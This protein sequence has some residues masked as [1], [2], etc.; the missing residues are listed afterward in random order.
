[1]SCVGLLRAELD[2]RAKKEYV[3]PLLFAM[4]HSGAG[5]KDKAFEYLEQARL[6]RQSFLT[7]LKVEPLFDDIRSDPRFDE[8][9]KK[10]G[11]PR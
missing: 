6:G 2:A 8:L 11:I 5:N 1:M 3:P 4:I 9:V 10:I 7:H